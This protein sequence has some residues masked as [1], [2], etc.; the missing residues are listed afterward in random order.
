M[1]RNQSL[2]KILTQE[3]WDVIIVGG[4]A[5]GLGT[6][7]DSTTRGLK[8]LLIERGDFANGTSSKSTKLIHGGVRYL[9]QLQFKLVFEAIRERKIL[10]NNA[11][12]L[13]NILSFIVPVYSYWNLIYY[14][15]GLYFYA[16]LS[17]GS[18]IGRT[19]I[20]SKNN[21]INS[22]NDINK[23]GLKGGIKYFDGQ[24]NDSQL[25]IDIACVASDFKATVINYFEL[26]EVIKTKDKITG[27]IC[28]DKIS[29]KVY[30]I[31]CKNL[32]SA[33]GVFTDCV[34]KI[35]SHKNEDII[36]PSQGIHIV[37]NEKNKSQH[38][39]LMFPLKIDNRVL[40]LIPWMGKL[41]LGTTD[42]KVQNI[43]ENPKALESEITFLLNTYNTLHKNKINKNNI[44]SVF[45]GLRPL[46]KIKNGDYST[47]SASR[48]HTILVS[49]SNMITIVGGKW[50]TYRK[51]AEEVVDTIF[52]INKDQIRACK[53]KNISL[54]FSFIKK[55]KIA[56][57]IKN[58]KTLT[59]KIHDKY[60]FTKADVLYS[61]EYE[62]AITIEDI[63]ARRTSLL[64]LDTK[65]SIE[66]APIVADVFVKY[67]NKDHKWKIN[68]IKKFENYSKM[69]LPE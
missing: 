44:L 39:A 1:N 26:I 28:L 56:D 2:D 36:L 30:K 61:I 66:A 68:E 32:I 14:S 18:K 41:I 64:F 46:V 62:M 65:A 52:K 40:F 47:S 50:T 34:L 31:K 23:D 20:L 5:T 4:G 19:T 8:T 59:E 22:L 25:C 29:Q 38:N 53:T 15:L 45:V 67:L 49:K 17:V 3:K 13:S 35:D 21:T 6:A 54:D 51:M 42:T 60:S 37:L 43:C 48:E 55:E 63:L 33:T 12:H 57:L 7:L 27:I 58:D 16:L 9:S 69:Y 24:F 10:L 11:P